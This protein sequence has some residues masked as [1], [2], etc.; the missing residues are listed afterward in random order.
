MTS[1]QDD[2]DFYGIDWDGPTPDDDDVNIVDVPEASTILTPEQL[3]DL[4]NTY[5]P[6]EECEDFGMTIYFNVRR[7]LFDQW[8]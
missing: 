5:N 1:L 6:L 4:S 2:F 7:Y 3:A 8:I